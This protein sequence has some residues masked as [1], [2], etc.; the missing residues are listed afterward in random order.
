MHARAPRARV[1]ISTRTFGQPMVW[2]TSFLDKFSFLCVLINKWWTSFPWQVYLSSLLTSVINKFSLTSLLSRVYSQQ[3][4]LDKFTFSCVLI[5]KWSTSFLDK[6]SFLCRQD[7]LLF[8]RTIEVVLVH[9]SSFLWRPYARTNF[10]C[11]KADMTSFGTRLLGKEKLLGLRG[12][13]FVYVRGQNEYSFP[14][15]YD[16]S[17]LNF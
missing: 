17:I 8:T 10:P 16:H 14:L 9:S 3:V 5:N 13:S 7:R 1:K 11:P 4:F 6:F 15:C 2:S 12:E